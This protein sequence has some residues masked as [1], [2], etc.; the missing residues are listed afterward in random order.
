M[1]FPLLYNKN[2]LR[3]RPRM[4]VPAQA[5]WSIGG[6]GNDVIIMGGG[7]PGATGATGPVGPSGAV[8][9]T[10]ATGPAGSLLVPVVSVESDYS[11]LSTDY[12]IGVITSAPFTITLPLALDG[13]TYIVKDVLGNA[14]TNP[15]TVVDTVLIDNS[16]SAQID[17]NFGSLTFTFNNNAWSIV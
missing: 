12:F 5:N 9:S 8:G 6:N 17:T 3:P 2:I 10:G 4:Y 11:A 7:T 16:P 15:I 1:I 14:A 13:T